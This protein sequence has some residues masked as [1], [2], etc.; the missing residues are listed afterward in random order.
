MKKILSCFIT[1]LLLTSLPT[2]AQTSGV[3]LNSLSNLTGL[4]S[5]QNLIPQLMG[6]AA[7]PP[8]TLGIQAETPPAEGASLDSEESI[9]FI[10]QLQGLLFDAVLDSVKQA[11][12]LE[13][14]S[15]YT[16]EIFG[17][18]F[19]RL[20]NVSVYTKSEKIKA[21]DSYTL[22]IGD[23]LS[24]SVYGSSLFNTKGEVNEEGFV[25]IPNMG[26]IY[27]K[28]V[29]L[30]SARKLINNMLSKYINTNTSRTEIVLNYSRNIT[31]NIVGD[32]SEPGSFVIPAINSVFNALNA[33]EGPS[34][35]GSVRSIKVIRDGKTVNTFDLYA[36]LLK[37]EITNDFYL[38]DG[39]YIFVPALKKVVSIEGSIRRPWKYELLENETLA[40]LIEMAGGFTAN[41]YTRSIQ[42]KRFNGDKVEIQDIDLA[43]VANGANF[44]LKDG[45]EI[46]IPKIPA[47]YENYVQV[48]GSVRFPGSY[49]LKEGQRIADLI[50]AAGGLT[51][52]AYL[53]RAYLTR[54]TEDLSSVIQHFN[55]KDV[56]I[57]G[58][59]G[60]NVLLQ[61]H[62]KIEVFSKIDFLEEFKVSIA[63]SVLKPVTKSYAEGMTLNDLIF[64]GG[65]LKKEAAGDIIEISRVV[66]RSDDGGTAVTRVVVKTVSIGADL[67]ID[68]ASK[69]FL[70]SPMDEVYVRKN[71]DF[72]PQ[73]NIVIKGE[74]NYPGT[75]PILQKDEKVLDLIARAGGLT[76]Y[77]FLQ[78]AKLYRLDK[79]IGT[80]IIDLEEAF[81][82]PESR[83]NHIL[84]EGDVLEIPT[85]NQLVSV[86][87]AIGHPAL[88]SLETIS[89]F[90]MPGRR[91]KY[92]VKHYGGGFD[93]YAK[94]KT[95][96]VV[97]PDGSAGYT[98]KVLFFNRYP[99]VKEGATVSVDYKQKTKRV[100]LKEE[101][102]REPV[103]WNLLLPSIII[104]GTSVIS[105]TILILT[106]K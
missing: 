47:D 70:L 21:P 102:P 94:K 98:K 92:Y 64:Y 50:E 14:D 104:G 8:S 5:L 59:S 56:V 106:L 100:K 65:G 58:Q 76:P 89:S 95:T 39:D 12:G 9:Y 79:T 55:L 42:V 7:L 37:G 19:F 36:F 4:N 31:V 75:Y 51:F 35:I 44:E 67:A 86:N 18:Q 20:K 11:S 53:D 78:S 68:D 52:N 82:S 93:K 30:G 13:K 41:S 62:D 85:V 23:E 97:N 40:D 26:R 2:F 33:A 49:E 48:L 71:P 69:S 96:K 34:N 10:K 99:S 45:D 15:V 60:E 57:S 101:T 54:K 61:K 22:D 72:A 3:N 83:A 81:R 1:V 27:L 87:G 17:H 25:E 29:T 105:S 80:V 63:G 91:A 103:N 24:I 90:Y 88:D 66:D 28:G 74:V 84:K 38:Q 32:V 6:T 73:M 77:A 43:A 16:S 46:I